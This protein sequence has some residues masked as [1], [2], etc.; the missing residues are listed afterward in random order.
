MVVEK[1]NFDINNNIL[2]IFARHGTFHPRFGWLKKGFD[3]AKEN[4][5][6]FSSEE[7]S[8]ELGVGK[9][10]VK[11]I[12][13]WCLAFKILEENKENNSSILTPTNFA[14]NLFGDNGWDSYL[15]NEASLWLLHWQLFK[16]T[17]LTPAWFFVFN[18][19][20]QTQ[21]NLNT[22]LP[23]LK[24]FRQ[25][26]FENNISS[27]SSLVKDLNCI[28][29]MYST[30]NN[31]E[32]NEDSINSPF[33]ELNLINELSSGNYIFNIGNKNN[34]PSKIIVA[35][36]LEFASLYEKGARTI[37]ISR[38]MY[39]LGSPGMI[40]KITESCL[41]EALEEVSSEFSGIS[42]INNS[43]LIQLAYD[44]SPEVLAKKLL[45]DYYN[46]GEDICIYQNLL[47]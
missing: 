25:D 2:P 39:E 20:K 21:F 13:Y 34:L 45:N 17:C 19:F 22:L 47:M 24:E 42:I 10:M 15:E 46:K 12:K 32:L 1:V 14:L 43:G 40:F 3:K 29:R 28:L 27:E 6:I 31:L 7:G 5:K 35:T 18:N 8:I 4:S 37:N 33:I 41:Y 9:N 26:F 44:S 11:A 30:K 38:L 36:C 23:E 16:P